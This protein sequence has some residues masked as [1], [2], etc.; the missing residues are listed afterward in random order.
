MHQEIVRLW[1]VFFLKQ[2]T[3]RIIYMLKCKLT[4][5]LLGGM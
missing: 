2:F 1:T 5:A 4:L 3:N